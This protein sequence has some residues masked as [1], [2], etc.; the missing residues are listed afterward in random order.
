M[1][2]TENCR[3]CGSSNTLTHDSILAPFLTYRMLNIKPIV[4]TSLYRYINGTNYLPCHTVGCKDCGFVGVGLYI[5]DHLLGTFY[6]NY[7]KPEYIHMRQLFE[8]D[9][10]QSNSLK[11][12]ES[13]S[14]V[15]EWITLHI[16]TPKRVLDY[17]AVTTEYTPFRDTARVKTV[18]IQT[19]L[20]CTETFDL[21]TCLHVL[22]HVPDLDRVLKTIQS[23][24][25]RYLY[26][27]VPHELHIQKYKTLEDRV[28]NKEIWHEHLNFFTH[29]SLN[30][31]LKK[32]FEI[33]A[34]RETD[35]T[36]HFLC[37]Y[38]MRSVS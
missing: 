38:G 13:I 28:Q 16:Q 9:F 22:E 37:T 31:L 18:D 4:T 8:P 5:S 14:D 23:Y 10:L 21:V 1:N 27:E 7:M 29:E 11:L 35:K 30:H 3:S 20:D 25:A 26:I 19:G 17:G 24:S 15:E 36:I 6:R 2:W 32:Y 12:R 34:S 33:V